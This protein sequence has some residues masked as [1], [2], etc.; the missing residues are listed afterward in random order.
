MADNNVFISGVAEDAFGSI[1]KWATQ[2]TAEDIETLLVKILGIQ[3]KALSQMLKTATSAGTTLSAKDIKEA[4]IE[5]E[6][7]AKSA[8]KE[9]EEETKKRKREKDQDKKE[10]DTDTKKIAQSRLLTMVT[11][12]LTSAGKK[13]LGIQK[14]YFET[15]EDLFKS[16]VNLLRNSDSQSSS[17][18]SLN[19]I[20]SLTGLRLEVFQKVVEKYSSSINAIGITKFAKT[21]SQSTTKLVALGYNSE[22]QAELIGTLIE[23]E[24]SYADIR[25]K[26]TKDLA[27]DAVRLGGQLTRLSLLTGQSA[28]QL[29]ENLMALSK[30][31]DSA[32]VSAVYGEK[33]AER[34]NVFASSFKD[35]DVGKMFQTLAATDSPAITKAFQAMA[36]AGGAPMAETF[37]DIATRARDGAISAQEANKRATEAA[38]SVGSE[39]LQTLQRNAAAGVEGSQE[40]LETLTKL[41][42]Q[43]NQTSKATEKQVDAA[44]EAQA[45]LSR[46]STALATTSS[47]AQRTFP[48]LES[49]V[50]AASHA[51]EMFNKTVTAGTDLFSSTTRSWVGVGAEVIAVLAGAIIMFGKLKGVLGTILEAAGRGGAGSSAAGSGKGKWLGRVGKGI[52]GGVGG[53]VAGLG[54]DYATDQLEKSGHTTAAA[55]TDIASSAASMA[56]TGALIGSVIPG[57][58]TAVGAIVG[59]VGG[60]GYGVYNNWSKISTPKQSSIDSPS[61]VPPTSSKDSPASTNAPTSSVLDSGTDKTART[62]DINNTL[63]YQNALLVQILESTQALVSVNRDILKYSKVHS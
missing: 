36:K 5:I 47:L 54:L 1:P 32:V 56:G 51:I 38:M 50:D 24:S 8:K 18:L 16:G 58:G 46:F 35:A 31:T 15:S 12:L 61:A 9:Y 25:G 21:L 53:V 57:I 27:D 55:A 49:Q 13:I 7:L 6:K 23:S 43:G 62:P 30:N 11:G 22:Q 63:S 19:Q 4:N 28:A 29:Q 45:S 52:A 42:A 39:T 34:M 37:V 40:F 60:A 2:A 10:S 20:I 59:A 48:L 26:S 3:T 17:L 33:A 44:I 14:Q 41:R